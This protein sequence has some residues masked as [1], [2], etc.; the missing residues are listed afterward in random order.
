MIAGKSATCEGSG[1]VYLQLLDSLVES[2]GNFVKKHLDKEYRKYSL[3]QED[4]DKELND[5][6]QHKKRLIANPKWEI[7]LE[8]HP[9][10]RESVD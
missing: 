4:F 3:S 2:E 6:Q 7:H 8:R 1:A 5:V 9:F 10:G